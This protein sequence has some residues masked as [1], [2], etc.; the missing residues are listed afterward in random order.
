MVRLLEVYRELQFWVAVSISVNYYCVSW[1]DNGLV[2]CVTRGN[3]HTESTKFEKSL[4]LSYFSRSAL[5]SQSKTN[6]L[7]SS[8]SFSER[9]CNLKLTPEFVQ[10]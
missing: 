10:F 5:K 3:E 2:M 7:F 9:T 8:E 4:F 6:V 1:T